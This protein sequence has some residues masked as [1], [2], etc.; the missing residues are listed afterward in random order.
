MEH[1]VLTD[2]DYFL[3]ECS[4]FASL[5]DDT[6]LHF[7]SSIVHLANHLCAPAR[8]GMLKVGS[9]VYDHCFIWCAYKYQE[10]TH[11]YMVGGLIFNE[12]DHTFSS[13]T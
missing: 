10:D 9:D 4:Y 5:G 7:L 1:I 13:H 2:P 11:P 12:A 8:T 3:Q 6:L